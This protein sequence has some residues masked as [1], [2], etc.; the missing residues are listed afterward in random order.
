MKI[1]V[2]FPPISAVIGCQQLIT[3]DENEMQHRRLKFGTRINFRAHV[4]I[5]GNFFS[6]QPKELKFGTHIT[7]GVKLKCNFNHLSQSSQAPKQPPELQYGTGISFR[8]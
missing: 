4:Q 1:S 2:I 3:V 6:Y 7:F 8:G 5:P